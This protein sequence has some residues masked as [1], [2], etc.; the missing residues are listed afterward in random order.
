MI[1]ILTRVAL[2]GTLGVT[3]A[4]ASAPDSTCSLDRIATK[5]MQMRVA[6]GPM[7]KGWR[8]EQ[9]PRYKTRSSL[10]AVSNNPSEVTQFPRDQEPRFK[11]SKSKN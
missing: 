3:A 10:P 2:L 8:K 11:N 7:P 5:N 9:D 4:S 1:S 6:Q